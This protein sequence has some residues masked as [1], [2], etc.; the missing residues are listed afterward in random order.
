VVG[1]AVVAPQ[2]FPDVELGLADIFA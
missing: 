1:R 2:A